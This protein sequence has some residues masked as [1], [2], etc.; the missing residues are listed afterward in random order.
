M[1]P[2]NFQSALQLRQTF[3][4]GTD[5][6]GERCAENSTNRA[7]RARDVR[8]PCVYE[9]E[10]SAE[11][12]ADRQLLPIFAR[13][14]VAAAVAQLLHQAEIET[15]NRKRLKKRLGALAEAEWNLRIG[16]VRVLYRIVDGRI[17]RILRVILKGT[18]TTDDAL[19]QVK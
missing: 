14:R 5:F 19:K 11:A 1:P 3:S 17:V 16:E 2:E 8:K 9:I 4:Q 15:R 13:G 6:H 7:T 10:W 12:E 18:A